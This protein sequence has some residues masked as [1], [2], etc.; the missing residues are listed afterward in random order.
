MCGA[1][2]LVRRPSLFARRRSRQGLHLFF[3]NYW[4]AKFASLVELGSRVLTGY[5][6]ICL[7]AHRAR[8]APAGI[9]DHLLG[10]VARMASQS[11]GQHEGLPGKFRPFLFFLAF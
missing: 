6:V 7:L 5:D 8:D 1:D 9:L 4:H 2:T 3:P 10:L 11:T